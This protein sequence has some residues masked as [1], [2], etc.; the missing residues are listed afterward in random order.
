MVLNSE[1]QLLTFMSPSLKFALCLSIYILE[2]DRKY[3]YII[4]VVRFISTFLCTFIYSQS[5]C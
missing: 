5:Y 3:N 1:T 2:C 4:V